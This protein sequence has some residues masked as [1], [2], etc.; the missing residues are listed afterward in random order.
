MK[1]TTIVIGTLLIALA[2]GA[3]AQGLTSKPSVGGESEALRAKV[4]ELQAR[5]EA[6]EAKVESMNKARIQKAAP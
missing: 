4:S 3:G 2:V 1:S 6:L 5:L